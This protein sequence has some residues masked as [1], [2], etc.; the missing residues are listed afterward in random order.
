M[1]VISTIGLMLWSLYAVAE[2]PE[3][4]KRDIANIINGAEGVIIYKVK[5][6]NLES[7][8]GPYFSYKIYTET[9]EELKG[10]APK[11]QCYFLR[12]EGE[13]KSPIKI[14][15]T[16]VAILGIKYTGECGAIEPGYGAPATEDYVSLF[17]SIIKLGT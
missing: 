8:N 17:K 9:I 16:R 6:V 11:G 15:E 2:I 12:S 3:W 10:K 5:A 1:R 13:W 14:G 7:L 4:Y